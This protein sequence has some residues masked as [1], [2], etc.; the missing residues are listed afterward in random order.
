MWYNTQVN[1]LIQLMSSILNLEVIFIVIEGYKISAIEN[2]IATNDQFGTID[3]TD[4]EITSVPIL[5]PL[6][7]LNTLLL[8]NNRI[9]SI[10]KQFADLTPSLE[11][12]VLTNNKVCCIWIRTDYALFFER[13]FM[14]RF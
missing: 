3:L 11:N 12:L 4:N 14:N 2:L 5:P 8:A 9:H 1:T 10:E 6:R 13:L 7:R